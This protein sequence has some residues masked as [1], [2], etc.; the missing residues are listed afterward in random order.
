[1]MVA[2]KTSSNVADT[3]GVLTHKKA[4]PYMQNRE[5]SW[6]EFDK[7]C[8]DQAED[9]NVP[10][11]ERPTF[12]AI[13]QS[14]LQEFFMVRVGS[15]TDL[16]LVKKELRDSKTLMTPAEQLDAIY[17][18]CHELYP[19]YERIYMELRDE[20]A[21]EGIH[22][23]MPEEL[24]ADQEKYLR[25]YLDTNVVPY[26]SP[27][28]INARHPF[29]HLE[30]GKLYVLIRLDEEGS[31][32]RNKSV[33]S[34]KDKKKHKNLGAE[35]ATFGLIPMPHQAKRV[36]KLP[37]EDAQFI[38]LEQALKLIAPDVFN[39]YKTKRASIICVT[40]NADIDPNSDYISEIDYDY[41]EHMKRI[42]KKRARLAPV[43]LE[44]DIP[45]SKVTEQ[46]LLEKLELEPHQVFIT[47]VSMDL[48]YCWGLGSMIDEEN[49]ARLSSPHF[50]PSWPA[51]IDP[52][53]S[54]IEQVIE[55]DKLLSYPYESMDPF[56]SLLQ[57]AAVDPSVGSIKI[58]LYR[59]ASQSRLA[60]ALITAA[61]N[62]KD[63]TALFE[64]RARFDE[65]NNI[66][67]SQRFEEAGA[68]VIYGF[69]DFKVHSKIC[70]ITRI[71]DE[72]LQHITQLGTGNYNEKT[73]R[74]YTDFSFMTADPDI[75]RDAAIFFRNMNL[76]NTSDAYQTLVV[77]PLQIKPLILSKVDEQIA[78]AQAG[79]ACG[80]LFKTNSVTDKDI[81]DKLVEA[82]QAGVPTTLFVRGI[83]CL[84]PGL[85]GYTEN[86]RVVSIVGRMLE[87][88]RIY[89]FGPRGDR[90]Y[91][92]SSADLMTRNMDKRIEIAWP[93]RGESEKARID[94][95][96]DVCLSDTAK[97]R[98]L[99]PN[100]QYTPL[101]YFADTDENGQ[102][103]SFNAQEYLIEKARNDNDDAIVA[104][105]AQADSVNLR[106]QTNKILEQEVEP[107]VAKPAAATS[108]P[109]TATADEE[110]VEAD[111]TSAEP[112][113][114]KETPAPKATDMKAAGAALR[115][116]FAK[117]AHK[118]ED[119]KDDDSLKA[120][121]DG[122]A[123]SVDVPSPEPTPSKAEEAN[124][125][126]EAPTNEDAPKSTDG[127]KT[128]ADAPSQSLESA[129][130]GSNAGK[131]EKPENDESVKEE[132][133]VQ[134]FGSSHDATEEVIS[135][136]SENHVPAQPKDESAPTPTPIIE[137]VQAT[138]IETPEP[139]PE[140]E[141]IQV[142]PKEMKLGFFQR[143]KL[144][145]FG[146]L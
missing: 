61:E 124:E 84:I 32:S 110:P 57:E 53:R 104:R 60:E 145:F 117:A 51:C 50:E 52:N 71:T 40:R 42:L 46:F 47:K 14:N 120:E 5:L 81:I 36:I 108:V 99:Q 25:L 29:P 123:D 39:M 125:E 11:L 2:K 135:K 43:R 73:S 6:L 74:L 101:E 130:P 138:V 118:D 112:S 79:K 100:L 94:E 75:G 103:K 88:S 13:F 16:S 34:S 69:H 27:Q 133:S 140:A 67:W 44:S 115:A 7:R 141:G 107:L 15:L 63:V 95:F 85:E 139:A 3:Q 38:L 134:N 143:L 70:S 20:L 59:L 62:G 41:R 17:A 129:S 55:G 56:V 48:S 18:R 30:N 33:S 1:M 126:P 137:E 23:V 22:Q 113:L 93:V 19:E 91:Y 131:D 24:D 86:I 128:K 58:T 68:K 83:S 105:Q 96:L 35:D 54:I 82:S 116:A 127:Q 121:E 92:L 72:G 132:A 4:M 31:R 28:V 111:A 21:E 9:E 37:G 122:E 10:L 80:L 109:A 49:A 89:A 76:E 136:L 98:M 64:L 78:L 77:A 87:H 66:E 114:D 106:V 90:E 142:A 102:I 65:S 26:L 146:K 97:L 144:L 8:L 119:A 45:L 12:A